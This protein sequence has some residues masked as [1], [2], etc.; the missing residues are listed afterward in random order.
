MKTEFAK[1][2]WKKYVGAIVKQKNLLLIQRM[3]IGEFKEVQYYDKELKFDINNPLA[4]SFYA[5][6]V[7]SGI[8]FN[9]DKIQSPSQTQHS[10]RYAQMM[11]CHPDNPDIAKKDMIKGL[12]STYQP[13]EACLGVTVNWN[14]QMFNDMICSKNKFS[15]NHKVEKS[16]L[17]STIFKSCFQQAMTEI[18]LLAKNNGN[19]LRKVDIDKFKKQKYISI[20]DEIL[21][22][23]YEDFV[24]PNSKF[25]K[26]YL[27]LKKGASQY[28][29]ELLDEQS[30]SENEE[31]KE[32]ELNEQQEREDKMLSQLDIENFS[33]KAKSDSSISME[34]SKKLAETWNKMKEKYN[35]KTKRSI[36]TTNQSVDSGSVVKDATST[37]S[38]TLKD[39]FKELKQNMSSKSIT[40]N[41]KEKMTSFVSKNADFMH[42]AKKNNIKL[43]QDFI[44]NV[45]THSAED[46]KKMYQQ[47]IEN[48]NFKMEYIKKMIKKETKK[49]I[50]GL[51][52]KDGGL[53]QNNLDKVITFENMSEKLSSQT[54][55]QTKATEIT[56]VG[57][58][59]PVTFTDT[60][61][62]SKENNHCSKD[63]KTKSA[64][65]PG[66]IYD[67]PPVNIDKNDSGTNMIIVVPPSQK[68]AESV[69]QKS[70]EDIH[71]NEIPYDSVKNVSHLGI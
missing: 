64:E 67:E 59:P 24:K 45:L 46:V 10:F 60:H 53:W 43:D 47:K 28:I 61:N 16:I 42:F 25:S 68:P 30:K 41:E 31:N 17:A 29:E 20:L 35:Q 4:K 56:L 7:E 69:N 34:T 27:F 52:A 23:K 21:K 66:E 9:E 5:T 51:Q 8:V 14:S 36:N 54:K 32:K 37:V 19:N 40:N 57:K 44:S 49:D 38:E 2:F 33:R 12:A 6:M 70:N 26:D 48:P 62:F 50:L 71:D 39:T 65:E 11:S 18:I 13:N 3:Q 55:G 22:T 15:L 63:S 58:H 1:E